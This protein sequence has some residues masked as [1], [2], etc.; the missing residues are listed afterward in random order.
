M[1]VKSFDH[2]T[3]SARSRYNKLESERKPYIDRAQKCA[4]Y[5]IPMLFP[6]DTDNASTTYETTYQSIGARGVNNL[7]SKLMLALFPPNAPFFRLSLGSD[8]INAIGDNSTIK[9]QWEEALAKIERTITGYME[10]HQIRTTANEAILQLVVAGNALLFLP[11]AE[12]GMKLYRLNNY[13]VQR[14]GI[15]NILEI[16]AKEKIAYGA[17]PPEA[18]SCI[19]GEDVDTDKIYEVYTHTYLEGDT[20]KS[21]QEIEGKM[22]GGTDQQYPKDKSPWIPIRLRKMDGENYGRSFVDEYL[23]DLKSLESL[24]KSLVQMAAVAANIIFL[25]NPNSTLRVSELSKAQPGAFIKG[26]IEDIQPM[27]L[28]KTTDIQIAQTMS[29]AIETRLSYAFLLNSAV[30]RNAERVTA[31]EIRYVANE[32]EDTIGGIYSILSQELQLPLV[33]RF[34]AQMEKLGAIPPLPQGQKG[35]EPQITTG[36]EAL[37]RGHDLTK[38]DTFLRY[39]QVI[40]EAFQQRLK[41]GE[42]MSMLATAIGID[43]SSLIKTDEEIQ[44]EQ[45]QMQENALAQNVVPQMAAGAMRQQ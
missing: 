8:V 1:T 25:V 4:Q 23:G 16:I 36:I 42:L 19:D 13:V 5:T 24:S 35:V 17:M 6:K 18:Q 34:M 7:A 30:Q 43:S 31:E 12:G 27:Q 20:Y 41:D 22:V 38:L 44:Q 40:P 32:L 14:D 2:N 28:N 9:T 39:A 3:T 21:Y 37:G 11:P 10:T 45:Q 26:K 15:G 29:Q 33:K